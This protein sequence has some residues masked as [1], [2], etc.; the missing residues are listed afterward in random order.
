[1]GKEGKKGGVRTGGNTFFQRAQ[2]LSAFQQELG[3][4]RERP[5]GLM[6]VWRVSR[7][8]T[9]AY[10]KGLKRKGGLFAGLQKQSLRFKAKRHY[11]D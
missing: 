9:G 4:D 8:E 3:N 10:E 2:R 11:R 5:D 1:L 7:S 6:S